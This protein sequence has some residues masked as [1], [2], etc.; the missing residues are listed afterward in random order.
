[1]LPQPFES[2]VRY[3]ARS[4]ETVRVGSAGAYV[5]SEDPA[6]LTRLLE[7]EE[8]AHLGLRPLAPTVL[9]ARADARSVAAAMS[10]AG[11]SSLVE[12]P[13]GEPVQLPE[14][15]REP[16]PPVRPGTKPG[17]TAAPTAAVVR[18]MRAGE[19][20]AREGLRAGAGRP[21][22][23]EAREVLRWAA[24]RG[25]TVKLEMAGA[26]GEVQSRQVRPL[27]VDPGRIRV[28]DVR[29]DAEIT[30]APHRIAAVRPA[31]ATHS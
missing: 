16:F 27:R 21:A 7:R 30:V 11:V 29:R 5:R 20:R 25:A 2:L 9:L 13:D 6:A 4:H 19:Q 1:P 10:E 8:L 31:R 14:A 22:S 24:R 17:E 28:L 18:Q 15:G 23:A 3:V 12:G 26:R